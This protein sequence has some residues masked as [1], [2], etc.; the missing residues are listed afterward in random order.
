MLFIDLDETL[1][2]TVRRNSNDPHDHV[3]HTEPPPYSIKLG[4]QTYDVYLRPDL[5]HL[6]Y[7]QIPFIIFSAGE[8]EYVRQM[9]ILIRDR[10]KLNIRG[11]LDRSEMSNRGPKTPLTDEEVVLIDER[12]YADPVVHYKMGRFPN[13]LHI[14]IDPWDADEKTRE[15]KLQRVRSS[16]P[17]RL[18]LEQVRRI[19]G[20]EQ[21]QF[22]GR[23]T[24]KRAV[25]QRPA[26]DMLTRKINVVNSLKH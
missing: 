18:V 2:R 1:V 10:V 6:W 24:V 21:L 7:S 20:L 9:A 19:F 11:F 8:R 22:Q 15:L 25:L 23:S 12:F 5:Y 16:K 17:L 13:G 4:G 26:V 14:R 3:R